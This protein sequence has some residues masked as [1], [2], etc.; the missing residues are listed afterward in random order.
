MPKQ[1][2]MLTFP[3]Q[4]PIKIIGKKSDEFEVAALGIIRKHF[5]DLA[6]NALSSKVSKD[7]HYLA[8]TVHVTATSQEQLDNL[9]KELSSNPNVLMVL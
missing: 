1:P 8:F 5:P 7:D 2:E 3:C 9:Y 6:E 4:F